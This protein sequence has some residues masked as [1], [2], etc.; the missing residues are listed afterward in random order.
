M[1]NKE[2]YLLAKA[3]GLAEFFRG[4]EIS[5]RIGVMYPQNAQTALLMNTVQSLIDGVP[6]LTEWNEYQMFRARVKAEVDY[7]ISLIEYGG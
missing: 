5:R 2:N 1:I 4:D 6:N 7:E 3:N